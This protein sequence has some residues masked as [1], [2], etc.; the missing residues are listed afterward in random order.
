[1]LR[2]ARLDAEAFYVRHREVKLPTRTSLLKAASHPT[3]IVLDLL[4]S[5]FGVTTARN[6]GR[7]SPFSALLLMVPLI[8]IPRADEVP[9]PIGRHARPRAISALPISH[10]PIAPF[11]LG[12]GATLDD[13]AID[14]PVRMAA[15]PT[16]Y[17][18]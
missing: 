14:R 1:M 10:A 11:R 18:K 15:T 16:E 5:L 2:L 8:G 7:R 6:A 3:G 4:L 13:L 17:D 12:A 9:D